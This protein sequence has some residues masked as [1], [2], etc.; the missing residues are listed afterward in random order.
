[1][2]KKIL[3]VGGGIGG[4]E[5]AFSL[6]HLLKS[7]EEIT[8]LDRSD[9][10]SFLPSIHE[11]I[12]GKVRPHDIEIPFAP[13]LKTSRIPFVQTEILSVDLEERRVHTTDEALEYDYL[14][15][16]CGAEANYY[17]IPGAQEF[18]HP[19]RTPEQAERIGQEI[20]EIL[21]D[22]TRPCRIIIAGGGLEGVEV[23]GELIDLIRETGNQEALESGG[24]TIE[25]VEGADS[26]LPGCSQSTQDFVEQFLANK[27][28]KISTKSRIAKVNG[29]RIVLENDEER[30]MS[31]L[32]WTGGIQPAKFIRDLP[33][34]KDAGGWLQV[35]SDL[36][37]T[38]GD[39]I[40]GVGDIISVTAEEPHAPL[41][42][43][44]Y[45]ALD[46]ARIAAL[47]IFYDIRGRRK[48]GYHPKIKPQLISLG[49]KMGVL[50]GDELVLSGSWV[51]GLKKI[52][53]KR[54]L[55]TYR[56]KPYSLAAAELLPGAEIRHLARLFLPI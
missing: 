15:L 50:T 28:I 21:S 5:T 20:K 9:H 17:G 43:V 47:N 34:P 19:F 1:M 6:K 55:W 42:R 13:L 48:I 3:V 30:E 41:P 7:K 32:I 40:F 8:L 11:V 37:S 33:L 38:G 51:V 2:N 53:E 36:N 27:G 39:R 14:V 56:Q 25:L 44:A 16:A 49:S 29:E 18:A 31:I 54:H 10:Q 23:A 45:Y 26:L 52:V 46:Q 24:V 4:L 12:S 22:P 35:T